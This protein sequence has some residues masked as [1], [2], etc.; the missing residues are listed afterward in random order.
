[1]LKISEINQPIL[2]LPVQTFIK[3]NWFVSVLEAVLFKQP[4]GRLC[5]KIILPLGVCITA[6]GVC[7]T[8]S[9]TAGT[10][11]A[12]CKHQTEENGCKRHHLG[13]K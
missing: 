4:I 8:A 1:M 5:Y 12:Y 13:T 11:P 7:I 3:F 6:P 2:K 9:I 10:V